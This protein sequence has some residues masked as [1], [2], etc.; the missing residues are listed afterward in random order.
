M[1]IQGLTVNVFLLCVSGCCK[2]L[3]NPRACYGPTELMAQV[4]SAI[5]ANAGGITSIWSDHTFR[6]WIHDDRGKQHYVDGDGVL[7]FRKT[8][9]KRDELLLQGK[10]VIG[11][12]FEI[13]SSSG[14]EAQYWVAV[15][16]EVATEWWGYY[17]NLGKPCARPVPIRP[18]L[19]MEVL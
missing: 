9:D 14:P 8:P 6:A 4:I 11:K 17:K 3:Q 2:P 10:S 18:D 13:G 19:V 1:K 16:P 12:I 7:L 5:N 15:V